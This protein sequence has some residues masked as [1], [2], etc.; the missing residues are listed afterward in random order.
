MV[1][2]SR[3]PSQM[4]HVPYVCHQSFSQWDS[5]WLSNSTPVDPEF[6]I[7][8]G[9]IPTVAICCSSIRN[10]PPPPPVRCPCLSAR[11]GALPAGLQHP[12]VA[13]SRLRSRSQ[14]LHT[15]AEQMAPSRKGCGCHAYVLV[16]GD[17]PHPLRGTK[18]C[19]RARN[20]PLGST[21][22]CPLAVHMEPF[23]TFNSHMS[24]Y[25]AGRFPC[26]I[27]HAPSSP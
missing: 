12:A 1:T 11:L 17:S 25:A 23:S 2:K 26:E 24:K 27:Q 21:N 22:P 13:A 16:G 6:A 20:I 10:T 9:C 19:L 14:L 4:N 15:N 7:H 8:M 18:Q 3:H 5:G